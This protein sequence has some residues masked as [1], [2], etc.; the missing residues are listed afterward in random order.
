[1]SAA[2]TE[3]IFI[4][5]STGKIG[6]HLVTN[7]VQSG[8]HITLFVRD[9]AKAEALFCEVKGPGSIAY[10]V[11]VLA[12]GD[13]FKNAIKGHTRLFLLTVQQP[14][15]ASLVKIAKDV[16]VKHVVKISCIGSSV[17]AEPGSIFY[18]HGKAEFDIMNIDGIAKTFLRPHDFMDNFVAGPSFTIKA[19]GFFSSNAGDSKIA[20]ID[21]RDIA[22]VAAVIL[23]CPI[24]LHDG[25]GYTLTGP[26]ALTKAELAGVLSKITGKQVVHKDVRDAEIYEQ[27]KAV[28]PARYALL[29]T[30]LAHYYKTTLNGLVTGYVEIITGKP[31][32]KFENYFKENQEAFA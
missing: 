13:E 29:L 18:L 23:T 22:D 12:Q 31:A 10:A 20:S 4:T 8:A 28:M 11:G 5:G 2:Y 9:K 17:G 16:G 32:R 7:L 27:Y 21:A 6:K 14:E 30:N 1:M 15:E 26:E 24:E 3:K 25:M 19:G